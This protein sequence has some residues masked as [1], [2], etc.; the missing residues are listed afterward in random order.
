M[1]HVV[2]SRCGSFYYRVHILRE[3]KEKSRLVRKLV[4]VESLV[5]TTVSQGSDSVNFF[6]VTMVVFI[7]EL[8]P[9]PVCPFT[10]SNL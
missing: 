6:C 4:A 8:S 10:P 9:F 7:K 2:R 1:R 5:Q 3:K